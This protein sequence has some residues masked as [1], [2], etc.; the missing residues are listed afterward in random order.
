MAEYYLQ[1]AYLVLEMRVKLLVTLSCPAVCDPVHCSPPGS[2]VHEFLRVTVLE[3]VAVPLSRG[4]SRPRDGTPVSLIVD[5]FFTIWATREGLCGDWAPELLR[6]PGDN[7]KS[8]A[9]C[10]ILCGLYWGTIMES[11]GLLRPFNFLS[12]RKTLGQNVF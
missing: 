1:C 11:R 9:L 5:R 2:S 10:V 6:F 7:T 8:P 12:Q 4:S 3:W